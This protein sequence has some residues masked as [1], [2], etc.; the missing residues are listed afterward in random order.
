M[1]IVRTT[2]PPPR[3]PFALLPLIISLPIRPYNLRL[4]SQSTYPARH[5]IGLCFDGPCVRSESPR[6]QDS[7]PRQLHHLHGLFR[8]VNEVE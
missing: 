1:D 2:Y 8:R 4:L 3:S 7:F 5:R 6:P